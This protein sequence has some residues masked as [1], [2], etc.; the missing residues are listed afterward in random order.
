MFALARS[1]QLC[2]PADMVAELASE[3]TAETK[4]DTES[5]NKNTE[6][7]IELQ[8]MIAEQS[9]SLDV[10]RERRA[11]PLRGKRT[12]LWELLRPRAA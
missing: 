12:C 5:T 3:T 4:G 10:V 2:N 1:T 9:S 11:E 7:L 8:D 6:S